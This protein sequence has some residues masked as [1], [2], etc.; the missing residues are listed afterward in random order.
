MAAAVWGIGLR[1][2]PAIFPPDLRACWGAIVFW[3]GLTAYALAHPEAGLREA[4]IVFWASPMWMGV[5]G[6]LS[7]PIM[8]YRAYS[9]VLGWALLVSA[10]A[11]AWVLWILV[12]V[13]SVQSFERSRYLRSPLIFWGRVLAENRGMGERA[14]NAYA[15]AALNAGMFEED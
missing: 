2:D 8:E 12:A 9:A 6:G 14:G 10:I 13:W 5:L 7:D 1:F 3:G 11:P 15:T 4:V